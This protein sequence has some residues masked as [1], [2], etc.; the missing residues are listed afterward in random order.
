[1]QS[2]AF[3][4]QKFTLYLLKPGGSNNTSPQGPQGASANGPGW[5]PWLGRTAAM[6]PP[7]CKGLVEGWVGAA[8]CQVVGKLQRSGYRQSVPQSPCPASLLLMTS[9]RITRSFGLGSQQRLAPA[10][11]A[12][13]PSH[14]CNASRQLMEAG[15]QVP[16]APLPASSTRSRSRRISQE[17]AVFGHHPA[18]PT[19]LAP[20]GKPN[21]KA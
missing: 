13:S 16:L 15:S 17:A 1:M 11:M 2:R 18:M 10:L 9:Q 21:R 14:S 5:V 4:S 12:G 19:L 7:P 8:K 20:Q 3:C 6:F